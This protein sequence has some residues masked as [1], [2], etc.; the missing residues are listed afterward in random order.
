MRIFDGHCDVLWK[1]WENP[2]ISFQ[3][4]ASMHVTYPQLKSRRSSVQVFA[5]YVPQKVSREGQFAAALQMVDIFFEKILAF[6]PGMKLI[7]NEAELKRLADGETGAILSL[8]GCDCIGNDLSRLRILH[9]LGVRSVGLTWNFGNA[10]ADGILEP[11][12][13][14]LTSF[15]EEVVT[16]LNSKN[17]WTDVSHLS[18]RGFWDCLE[19]ANN[20]VATHS[21]AKVLC[22]HP[23]NLTD[24]QINGLIEKNGRIGVTFVP[25][26]LNSC[27][28]S[29]T[30]RDILKHLDH[31]CSLG[32]VRHVGF[33][34]D[35]D[36]IEDTPAGLSA[37]REYENLVNE[38]LKRYPEEQAVRF[39]YQNFADYFTCV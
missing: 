38:V 39:F 36:G 21:N 20:I 7:R 16:F 22:D 9:Q 25:S 33:G 37:Y 18:E 29:A 8:E 11:R 31:V 23:R 4:L 13:G 28:A 14:G 5:I 27:Q 30:I 3:D 34:S 32:G 24:S 17:C 19:K 10:A 6:S 12:G 2:D 15:G 26:F 1:M 35:F